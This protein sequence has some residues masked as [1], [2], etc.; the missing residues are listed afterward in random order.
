MKALKYLGI[1]LMGAFGIVILIGDKVTSGTL[2]IASAVLLLLP[3][4]EK[5]ALWWLR[6][7][8]VCV[9]LAFVAW[10]ISTTDLPRDNFF[11]PFPGTENS[12]SNRYATGVRF[13]DQ[14]IHIFDGFLEGRLFKGG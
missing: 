7:V 3:L 1:L 2:L 11:M 8:W 9:L 13:I 6:A 5:K 14:L 12:L 4:K 10:N